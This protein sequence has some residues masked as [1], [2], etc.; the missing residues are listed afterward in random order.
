M[1]KKLQTKAAKVEHA[2]KLIKGFRKHLPDGK[3]PLTLRGGA[4]SLRVDDL[5]AKLQ[6]IIDR[7]QAVTAAQAAAQNRV[8]EEDAKAGEV[9]QLLGDV[10]DYVRFHF[11]ALYE[12]LVD[13]DVEARKERTP[14]TS[15]QKAVATAKRMATREKR[16]IMPATKRQALKA[17]VDVKFVVTPVNVVPDTEKPSGEGPAK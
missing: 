16:G 6:A 8:L 2:A 15:E 10:D 12:D 13:F 9:E 17:N 11:G 5:V 4:L 3:Q 1:N 14:L 7:R